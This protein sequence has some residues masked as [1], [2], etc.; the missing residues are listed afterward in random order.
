MIGETLLTGVITN[1]LT[2]AVY[3]GYRKTKQLKKDS[4]IYKDKI[5]KGITLFFSEY[6]GV[7]F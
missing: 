3:L 7:A 2:D 1:L 4:P 5:Q 6:E